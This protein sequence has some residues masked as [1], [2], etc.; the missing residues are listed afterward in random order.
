VREFK[1]SF[2][3][4][5]RGSYDHLSIDIAQFPVASVFLACLGD[6]PFSMSSLALL[7]RLHILDI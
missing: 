5:L 4:A 1:F 2:Y 7:H 6:L 3:L